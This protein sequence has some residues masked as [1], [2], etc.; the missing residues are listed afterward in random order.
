MPSM[1]VSISHAQWTALRQ[2]MLKTL[3]EAQKE[4]PNL[5]TFDNGELAFVVHERSA[6][7]EAVLLA[8]CALDLPA[9]PLSEII[10]VE[11]MA[12]G[13]SDYSDKFALYC[14]ELVIDGDPKS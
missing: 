7:Y 14:A 3:V 9:I 11:N 5:R 2:A 8:R 4:R 10:R 13:H 6:M 12:S 1:K